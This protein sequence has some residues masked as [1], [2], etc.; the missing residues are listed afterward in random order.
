MSL[1]QNYPVENNINIFIILHEY[2]YNP[3]NKN[4]IYIDILV[5][6]GDK[7]YPFELKNKTKGNSNPNILLKQEDDGCENLMILDDEYKM[8]WLPFGNQQLKEKFI[9]IEIKIL[10]KY[11]SL[12]I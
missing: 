10:R 9:N 6:I 12:N 1:Y 3:N 4:T 7:W 11:H 2:Y 5:N 8:E